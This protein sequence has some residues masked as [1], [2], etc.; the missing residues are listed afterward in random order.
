MPKQQFKDIKGGLQYILRY[1][2][3]LVFASS[4]IISIKDNHITFWYQRHGDDKY[5]VEKNHI[6]DFLK[7]IIMKI[8]EK[9]FRTLRYYGFYSK[10]H[11]QEKNIQEY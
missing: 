2:G 9:D 11:K 1:C 5:V 10:H 7:R 4:R 6:Y 8:L 3:C